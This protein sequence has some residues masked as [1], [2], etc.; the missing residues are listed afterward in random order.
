MAENKTTKIISEEEFNKLKKFDSKLAIKLNQSDQNNKRRLIRYIEI[1]TQDK[2]FKNRLG[3]KKYQSLIIGLNYS[4]DILKQRIAKRL[5]QRLKNENLISEV[6]GLHRQGISWKK[7]EDFGLEYKF[8][9]LYLQKK[10]GFKELIEQLN[11]AISQ[12]SKRQ[13]SWFRRWEKQGAKIN[14][15]NNVRKIEILVRD[16]I[17]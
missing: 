9:S 14:W 6:D 16:F 15:T 13:I 2:K 4:R 5:I 3:K 17:K 12:F 1:L 11:I 7:L 10:I 8:I